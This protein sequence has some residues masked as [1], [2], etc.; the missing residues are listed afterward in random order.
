MTSNEKKLNFYVK[1]EYIT[2]HEFKILNYDSK[3]S[4]TNDVI[5]DLI[6]TSKLSFKEARDLNNFQVEALQDDE[7]QELFKAKK[8]NIELVQ[9][10]WLQNCI[11]RKSCD[12]NSLK[13]ALSDSTIG[14]MIAN[15]HIQQYF[16]LGKVD[17][18]LLYERPGKCNWTILSR[19]LLS[20][21]ACEI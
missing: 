4:I 20:K 2:E 5:Y 21:W 9:F 12:I 10:P 18:S 7:V 19:I 8:V 11:K 15:K 14:S 17:V 3:N 13:N 16:I 6:I 1:N